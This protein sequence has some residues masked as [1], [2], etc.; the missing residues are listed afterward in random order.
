MR[1]CD[2]AG[3]GSDPDVCTTAK[4]YGAA[5][6]ICFTNPYLS[7][8]RGQKLAS[9]TVADALQSTQIGKATDLLF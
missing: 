9:H 3:T 6:E 8:R 7:R 5:N 1:C 2:D 4:T